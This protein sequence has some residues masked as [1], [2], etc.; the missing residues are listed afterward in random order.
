[1]PGDADASVTL[2]FFRH[3]NRE[4]AQCLNR[5]KRYLDEEQLKPEQIAIVSRNGG[6]YLTILQEEA[7]RLGLQGRLRVEPRVLLL[8]PLGRF[9]LTLYEIH[10]DQQ[11]E[12]R[13]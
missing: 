12:L 1:M 2:E 9:A 4:V 8:T 10:N 13:P 3:R 5:V 11:L 6:E 7:R